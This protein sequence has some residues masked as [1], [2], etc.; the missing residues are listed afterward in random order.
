MF[1]PLNYENLSAQGQNRTADARLFR[2]PLYQLSYLSKTP[3]EGIEPSFS[4]L[5]T[6]VFPLNYPD[7][8][9]DGWSRT[10]DL[11]LIRR[12]ISPTDIRQENAVWR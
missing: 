1:F 10:S 7:L 12:A 5:E 4:V 2:P 6:A 8:S 11:S 3:G 9:P